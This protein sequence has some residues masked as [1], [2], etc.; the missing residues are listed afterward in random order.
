MKCLKFILTFFIVICQYSLASNQLITCNFLHQDSTQVN[1][2]YDDFANRDLGVI[3]SIDTTT[4][5]SSYY[6][7]LDKPYDLYQTLSN[8]GLAHQNLSFNYTSKI[9]FNTSFKT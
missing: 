6:D 7:L 1:F 2:F 3:Y 5:L 8:S 4:L 9:G